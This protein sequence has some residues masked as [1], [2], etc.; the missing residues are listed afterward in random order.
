MIKDKA[1]MQELDKLEEVYHSEMDE[2]VKS[3]KLKYIEKDE[4]KRVL[5]N[6]DRSIKLIRESVFGQ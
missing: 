1:D 2:F 3:F 6:M 5:K 4:V